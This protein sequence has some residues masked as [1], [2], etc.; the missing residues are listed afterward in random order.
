[1]KVRFTP[2]AAANVA[3]IGR[4]IRERNPSSANRVRSD[5]RASARLLSEQPHFGRQQTEIGVR[6]AVTRRYGYI[7][8]YFVRE[9]DDQ[10]DILSVMHPAR[11]RRYSDN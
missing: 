11:Q 9:G 1:M 2:E 5:I 3:A 7:V 6:K 8:Y 4:Y 10:L